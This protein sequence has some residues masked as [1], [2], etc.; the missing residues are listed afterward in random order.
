[1]VDGF[2]TDFYSMQLPL[3]TL[4]SVIFNTL[5]N[6]NEVAGQVWLT[7]VV[8]KTPMLEWTGASKATF[9]RLASEVGYPLARGNLRAPYS[10]IPWGLASSA[11]SGVG[12]SKSNMRTWFVYQTNLPHLIYNEYNPPIPGRY[13][14]P[15]TTR[16]RHTPYGFQKRG[17]AAWKR[18][19]KTL[20]LPNPW[21]YLKV[22]HM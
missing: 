12:E 8:R 17:A 16:V 22:E 9:Q 2:T 1:M 20:R 3:K 19:A 4:K 10:R 13:P 14:H 18:Y 6:Y 15:R 5:R 11:G 7:E 21:S